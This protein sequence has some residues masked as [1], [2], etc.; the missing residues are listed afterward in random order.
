MDELI[1]HNYDF[2]NYTVKVRLTLGY[3][4]LSWNSVTIPTVAPKPNLE[5]LT[6]G[7]TP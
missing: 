1:L 4:S 3:K 7:N 5:A 6:G 2:S